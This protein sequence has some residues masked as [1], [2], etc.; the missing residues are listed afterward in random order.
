MA[1]TDESGRVHPVGELPARRLTDAELLARATELI[2]RGWS[3][4]ALARNDDGRIVEPWDE[5]ASR[6]SLLGALL[7]AWYPSGTGADSLRR[8]C[9][10]AALATGGRL[11]EWNAAPW[12]TTRHVRSALTRARDSLARS[13]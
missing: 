9:T 4:D 1:A 7:A 10:A 3:Q 12:R 2:E 11:E 8:I 13:Q 5:T 6:W